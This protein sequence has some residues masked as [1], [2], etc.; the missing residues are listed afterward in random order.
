M[1]SAATTVIEVRTAPHLHSGRSVDQIMRNVVYALLPMCLYSVWLFGISAAALIATT[2]AACV[3]IEHLSCRMAGRETSI[4]DFSVVITGILLGLTLPPGLPLWMGVVGAFIAVAPGKMIFGGLG[5]NVFNPALVG[6][7]FLQAAFPSMI[8]SYT[9]ALALHRFTEFI[10]TSLAIPFLK[11]AP[12]KDWIAQV[13]VDGFT[14]ATPLM[15]QKFEHVATDPWTLFIGARAGSSGETSALLILLGGGYLIAHKMMDWRIPAAMLSG[16][17]LTGGAYYL[18]NPAKYPGPLFVL[19]SGGLMLGALFMA[20]DPVASPVTP[21][22]MWIYGLLMGLITVLIRFEGGLPEGV[23]YAILLGNAF[24][25]LIDRLTQ[26]R[27]YGAGKRMF[28]KE[29]VTR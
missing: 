4:G 18:S 14:G 16:A 13:R 23:M 21:R 29:A 10:P 1:S 25:P 19:F 15:L 17:V 3:L 2:T 26:P 6:R 5:F 27:T 12:I 28:A 9:P 22:G 7:A 8:T 20:T 11:A 24:S